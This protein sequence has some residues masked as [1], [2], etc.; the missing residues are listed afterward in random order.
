MHSHIHTHPN[1][2]TNNYRCAAQYQGKNAFYSNQEFESRTKTKVVDLSQCSC[3]G[4]GVADGLSNTTTGHLRRAAKDNEPVGVGTRGL[5]LFLASKM[6]APANAKTDRWMSFDEYLLAFYP[7]DGFDESL[8]EAQKGYEGSSSDHFYTNSG[9]HR[10]AVRHLRCMCSPCITDPRL[11]SE[12]CQLSDWCGKVRHHNIRPATSSSAPNARPRMAL[13]SLEQ[14][15]RTLNTRGRPCERVVVCLV[16]E[17][18]DNP[19]DEPFY[20]ARVV[21]AAR[22]LDSDCLVG[23]NSYKAGHIVVNIK[24]YTYIDN[25]RG[26]RIYRLQPGCS[27]GVVYSV[28]SIVRS[29]HGIKFKS[30]DNGK[31]ILGRETVKRL[32]RWLGN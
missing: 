30:Y 7:D 17:D 24:W 5:V 20:L 18:D 2:N 14:F 21:S 8:Y 23:G 10:L 13:M 16:H 12:S 6:R 22:T 32:T 9:L 15:A 4:K 1:T 26:D 19:L 31:Y 11:F 28:E 25:S 29:I 3:H 27:R